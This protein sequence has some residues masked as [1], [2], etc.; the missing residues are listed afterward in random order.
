MFILYFFSFDFN[1][2][3]Q[4]ISELSCMELGRDWGRT[5]MGQEWQF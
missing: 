4:N 3:I 1:K 2:Q 5:E